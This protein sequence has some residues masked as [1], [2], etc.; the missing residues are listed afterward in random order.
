MPPVKFYRH[1]T[2]MV[3]KG[4]IVGLGT[5]IWHH[6]HIRAGAEIGQLCNIGKN[7]YVDRNAI[8]GDRCKIQNN[9]S[10][11]EGVI[12]QEHVFVGPH[13][14]FTNDKFPRAS[15]EWMKQATVVGDH[16]S[17]GAHATIVCGIT[18]GP[19][20]MIG[21]GAV[22]TADV[23]PHSLVYGNPARHVAYVCRLGHPMTRTIQGYE[24][25]KCHVRL[26]ITYNWKELP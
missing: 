11:Y 2:A 21:C 18:I 22:V 24:C 16:A 9:C 26:G 17:I 3:E 1:S 6:A 10:I 7:V 15:G 5:H 19:Y 25:K 14:T 20:A 23:M 8:V 4:A 12:L 13:V